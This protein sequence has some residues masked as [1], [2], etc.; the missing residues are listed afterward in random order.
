MDEIRPKFWK[1]PDFHSAATWLCHVTAASK[2][3]NPSNLNFDVSD[4]FGV[5]KIQTLYGIWLETIFRTQRWRRNFHLD[6]ASMKSG[7]RTQYRL[8]QI[9]QLPSK[10]SG[11]EQ[12]V[13]LEQNR[14]SEAN[15]A[16]RIF[17]W[18]RLPRRLTRV[19]FSSYKISKTGKRA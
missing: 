2:F 13:V 10:A 5:G 19:N 14:S 17:I 1:F 8:S 9:P 12:R 3:Y 11:S 18:A 16:V 4:S 6:I 15:L 7:S